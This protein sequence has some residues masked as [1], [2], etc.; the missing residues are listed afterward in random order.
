MPPRRAKVP[1]RVTVVLLFLIVVTGAGIVDRLLRIIDKSHE[2]GPAFGYQAP[3]APIDPASVSSR[4]A[5]IDRAMMGTPEQGVA[6]RQ[7]RAGP[8]EPRRAEGAT[9]ARR[10]GAARV[11]GWRGRPRQGLVGRGRR[12]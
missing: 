7:L 5:P 2:A 1:S 12:D 10:P 9:G 8:H 6:P 4:A 11:R 3:H